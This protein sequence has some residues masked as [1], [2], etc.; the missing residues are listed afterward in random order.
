MSDKTDTILV[1]AGESITLYRFVKRAIDGSGNATIEMGDTDGE[2]AI[3]VATNSAASGEDVLVAIAGYALVDFAENCPLG[4]E[5][6]TDT[7]GKA[8]I[9]DASNDY[10]LGYAAPEPV[11]GVCAQIASGTRGR[12]YLYAN[13]NVQVP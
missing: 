6:T 8:I 7:S 10:K 11:D 4:A 5:I 2:K 9:A 13:R 12:V 1:P 3:G